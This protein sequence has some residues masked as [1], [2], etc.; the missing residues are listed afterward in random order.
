MSSD[1]INKMFFE[2]KFF[3]IKRKAKIM[4]KE[5]IVMLTL[6][7]RPCNY[8]YPAMMPKT[9]YELILPP[10]EI[11]GNKKVPGDV[12]K[13][14]QW[15]L[16]NVKGAAATVLSLDT[17][18]YGGILPSRLHH[19]NAE[20]LFERV[21]FIKTLKEL[22]PNM[23]L[24]VFGLI[25]RCPS[26]SSDDE[27]P[28]YYEN[29]GAEI[30]LYGKYTHLEKLGKLSKE[31]IADFNRVKKIVEKDALDDYLTRRKT[32]LSV[33]MHALEYAKNDTIDYFIVPQDDSAVYGYTSMDQLIVREY[34][35]SNTLHMKT[36]MYPSAD[37]IGLTLLARAVA[38]LSKIRPK[39]YVHYSSTKGGYTIPQVEDRIVSETVKYH[40]LSVN[41]IQVYS[42]SDAD[43]LLA[44][45]VGSSMLDM[46]DAGCALA[47]DI[48]RNLAEFVNFIKYALELNKTVAIA[49]IAWLNTG[50]T[51][52]TK[53]LQKENMLLD[54]HA[55]AGWNTS[56]NTTG[57]ALCQAILY[58]CGGDKE[59]NKRFLLHRYYEDIGYMA[60]T[61]K[62]ITEN[63]LPG[64]GLDYYHADGEDGK[65]AELVKT[66]VS[67]Y[68]QE[69]YPQLSALVKDINVRM[70]WR[71]MF[72]VDIKLVF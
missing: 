20:E 25:M 72:E 16:E 48:E 4:S 44:V 56:S 61:R 27:E 57:T 68:M 67:E 71:R 8:H 3:T 2:R 13:I 10:K 50:D 36:A 63:F 24:Y 35:K 66:T 38:T 26:Y 31:D 39:I 51:E 49:D 46:G 30:H 1:K 42:L 21:D 41:G 22:N 52:L 58:M 17:L 55:Y 69:N 60:Y 23:K 15:L 6:D 14:S 29:Y 12:K 32:N 40:I 43:M 62:H 5:K 54:I 59:G 53:I 64:L 65:A 11:M 28:D 37:D 34:L 70:P 33:L 18:V 19:K 7:E 9:D 47:Y 45:N